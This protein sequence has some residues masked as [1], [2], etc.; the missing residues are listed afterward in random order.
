MCNITPTVIT[1]SSTD[2]AVGT[3]IIK[4]RLNVNALNAM[5]DGPALGSFIAKSINL[6]K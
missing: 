3:D 5:T 2:N 6:G 4:K 1:G